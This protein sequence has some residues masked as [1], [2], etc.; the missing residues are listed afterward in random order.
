MSKPVNEDSLNKL[1]AEGLFL[2]AAPGQKG[3]YIFNNT[4]REIIY[5]I[6]QSENETFQKNQIAA[7]EFFQ[8]R[9]QLNLAISHAIKSGDSDYL[10]QMFKPTLRKLINR[11]DGRN[12]RSRYSVS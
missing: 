9:G 1:T 6:A 7:S 12:I 4:A 8:L 3:S 2:M 11:G 5:E 10:R